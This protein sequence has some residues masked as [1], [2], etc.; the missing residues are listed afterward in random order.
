MKVVMRTLTVVLVVTALAGC[1]LTVGPSQAPSQAPSHARLEQ[2][3]AFM[4]GR[5]ADT[6]IFVSDLTQGGGW[7]GA[8]EGKADNAKTAFMS[9]DIQATVDMPSDEPPLGEVTWPDGTHLQTSL[10]SASAAFAAMV[11]ELKASCVG[12]VGA[13]ALQVT[14]A[15]L[16]TRDAVTSHGNASV[17]VWQFTFAP[18]DE[19]IDPISYVAV[20][21]RVGP[22]DWSGG[23]DRPS[24]TD[25]AYGK[26]A[27]TQITI[28]FTGGACDASHSIVVVESAQAIVPLL[29]TVTR[30]GP[31]TSQGIRYGLLVQLASPLGNRVVLDPL[32]GFPVPV[33]SEDPP[34]LQPG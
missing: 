9:G 1:A 6:I 10:T 7:G 16:T 31:C 3:A 28:A 4:A 12:C 21:D 19:P 23:G 20:K 22:Q 8:D 17:P 14:G 15:E 18:G 34:A 25:A 33:Y 2:W 26:P 32:S 5:P 11:A 24:I 13:A 29:S 30:S 27:D